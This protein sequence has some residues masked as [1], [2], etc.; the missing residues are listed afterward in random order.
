[1]PREGY[2]S[3]TIPNKL[4]KKLDK[5]AKKE[6]SSIPRAIEE[7]ANKKLCIPEA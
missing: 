5:I 3:I 4:K 2:S 7:M 1:M 6:E